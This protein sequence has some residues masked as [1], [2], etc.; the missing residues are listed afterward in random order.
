MFISKHVNFLKKYLNTSI[1]VSFLKI[2]KN[3]KDF[4]TIKSI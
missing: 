3:L 1:L 4:N 2:K